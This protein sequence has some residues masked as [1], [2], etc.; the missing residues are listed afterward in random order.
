MVL[1][2]SM[3]VRKG[4]TLASTSSS[5]RCDGRVQG[6]DLIQMQLEQEAMMPGHPAA[7]RRLQFV[8]RGV[9]A[10]VGQRCQGLGHGLAGD[11]GLD[12]RSDR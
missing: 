12:D 6:V 5:M 7:Q 3:A 4:S 2:I 1:S 11:Q 8:G 10:P 9:D